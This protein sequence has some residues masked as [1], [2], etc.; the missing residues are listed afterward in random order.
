MRPHANEER[1]VDQG[2]TKRFLD[3]HLG[4]PW[5]LS[6]ISES[7]LPDVAAPRVGDDFHECPQVVL[8]THGFHAL[9]ALIREV[10]GQ[11][12]AVVGGICISW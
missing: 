5:F 11:G 7:T 9:R 3:G 12:A 4:N 1:K 6:S 2:S 8:V 10:L